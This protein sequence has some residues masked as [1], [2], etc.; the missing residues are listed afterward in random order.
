MGNLIILKPQKRMVVSMGN[1]NWA[2]ITG[3][4]HG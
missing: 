2:G 3:L 1:A 4:V